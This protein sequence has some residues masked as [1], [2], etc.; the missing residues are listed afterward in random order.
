[1]LA[2]LLEFSSSR[3]N[4]NFSGKINGRSFL[5]GFVKVKI[6]ASVFSSCFFRVYFCTPVCFFSSNCT[7]CSPHSFEV[8]SALLSS[9]AWLICISTSVEL[10]ILC[11]GSIALIPLQLSLLI[12]SEL[13]YV[14]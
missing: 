7:V 5:G 14:E 12:R 6:T 3:S 11:L 13:M 1:M 4:R 9:W 8:I 2:E 10:N